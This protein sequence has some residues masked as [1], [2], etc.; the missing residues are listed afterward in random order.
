MTTYYHFRQRH[1]N[2]G[3]LIQPSMR[4]ILE[5]YAV[6][7]PVNPWRLATEL[8]LEE[9]RLVLAPTALSRLDSNF[10]F[11]TEDDALR[12]IYKMGGTKFMFEVELADPNAPTFKAD[13]DLI[14]QMFTTD[15]QPLW[16]RIKAM[17]IPYWEGPIAGTPELLTTSPL[18][19][20]RTVR[21]FA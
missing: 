17:A 14:S 1:R 9:R 5:G 13:F 4:G 12:Q 6:G 11:L 21:T 16:P 8:A 19:V 18:K 10:V 3:D 15:G 2:P 20:I 7:Q